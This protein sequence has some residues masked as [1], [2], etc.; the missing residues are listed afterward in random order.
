MQHHTARADTHPVS[1]VIATYLKTG[2]GYAGTSQG[3]MAVRDSTTSNM[4]VPSILRPTRRGGILLVG[5]EKNHNSPEYR[6]W[7]PHNLTSQKCNL[8]HK[9][10]DHFTAI[11]LPPPSGRLWCYVT[12][13]LWNK[14]LK[15]TEKMEQEIPLLGSS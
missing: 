1:S 10:T 9:W 12:C 3:T 15:L 14:F 13:R 8:S 2:T 11:K 7:V 6:D 5:S 4:K